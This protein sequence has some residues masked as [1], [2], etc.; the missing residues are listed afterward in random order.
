VQV[1]GWTMG[2]YPSTTV[3]ASL[4]PA[5]QA[6]WWRTDP[7]TPAAAAQVTG[8][9]TLPAAPYRAKRY[10]ALLL[11]C[12]PLFGVEVIVPHRAWWVTAPD[13]TRRASLPA[14]LMP[15]GI[16]THLTKEAPS[17]AAKGIYPD[18]T[19]PGLDLH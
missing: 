17:L 19:T 9:D 1:L 18:R 12:E 15:A 8:W 2:I 4:R 11:P 16:Y 6:T 3:R 10:L 13:T 14:R 5:Q 7:T